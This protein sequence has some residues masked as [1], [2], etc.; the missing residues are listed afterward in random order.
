MVTGVGSIFGTIL[1]GWLVTAYGPRKVLL[2]T[3]LVMTCF[4]FI[5]FFAPNKPVLLV[6]EIL[7]GFEW[8]IV[9]TVSS[10]SSGNLPSDWTI[11]L[12]PQLLLTHPRCFLSNC[13]STS[14]GK[15]LRFF[16][17]T[18]LTLILNSY[19]NICFIL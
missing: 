5:V 11:S 7:L 19:T 3:L 2:Y 17:Y 8:G 16:L 13:V 6:G 10:R 9:S 1:N 4:L 12:L 18:C 14:Q 15:C